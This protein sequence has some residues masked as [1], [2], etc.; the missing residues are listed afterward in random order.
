MAALARA[1]QNMRSALHGGSASSRRMKLSA[2][3]ESHRKIY[4]LPQFD[5]INVDNMWTTCGKLGTF[6]TVI[7][8][9]VHI[10]RPQKMASSL[11][12]SRFSTFPPSLLLRLLLPYTN[13]FFFGVV[14]S[15]VRTRDV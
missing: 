1:N 2:A 8:T 9:V 11:A 3:G 4:I 7:H 15:L 5:E 10:G 13:L 12:F 6:P 14:F